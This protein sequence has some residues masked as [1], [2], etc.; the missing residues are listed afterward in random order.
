M[1]YRLLKHKGYDE[2]LDRLPQ[3]VRHKA[4]WAQVLLGIRGRTPSVKGTRGHNARWRRTPVQGN[5]YYMWWIPRSEG[6]VAGPASAGPETNTILIHS[7]R[8]HDQTDE[9]IDAGSLADYE[10]IALSALDPRYQEQVDLSR[11]VNGDQMVLAA[12]KG[13]PGSGKTV[14]LLYLVKD[15]ALRPDLHK[16]LYV[17]YSSRLK[18]AAREFLLAQDDS[19]SQAVTI[20]TLGEIE[21]DLTGLSS[22]S[23]PFSEL[24]D[25]TRLV[26]GQTSATL[27][28]W[29]KHPQAL[30]TEIRAHLLGKTFPP[31][32]SIADG[33]LAQWI[34]ANGERQAA[35]YAAARDLPLPVATL[36][37]NFAERLSGGRFFQDQRAARRAIELLRKGRLPG[38]LAEADALVVDEVQ[39]LTLVQIALLG[40]LVQARM[41]RRPDALFVLTV[42]G[43]ESQIVQP[44]GF[45]W[46]VT[47][48]LLGEQLD[49]WPE[50]F[51]F[52]YQRRSPRNLGQL[53][54]NSWR[55][56][57]HLPKP[58]RPSARRQA[59]DYA[60]GATGDDGYGRILL[61]PPVLFTSPARPD[62]PWPR[63]LA[64][65]SDKPGRILIDLTET[66]RSLLGGALAGER[67]EVVFLAREIKGLERATVLIHGL[68]ATYERALRLRDSHED[69]NI[70][71]FEARRLFDEMRVALSRSTEK[72][73]LLE[74]M[75]APVLAELKI[76]ELS[77]VGQLSWDALIDTLL[78]DDMTELEVIEGY[79]DETDDLLEREM[80]AQAH[81][82]NR[83]AYDLAV[84][85]GDRALQREAEEQYIRS[86]LL[87]A[88]S[89]LR[90]GE[91]SPAYERNR[92]ATA[93]A[94]D[95][96]DPFL[97][98][99]VQD[100][101]ETISMHIAGHIRAQLAQ[102]DV[103]RQSKSY[104]AVYQTVQ[105]A[106]TWV[107]RIDDRALSAQVDE[108]LIISSWEWA[109]DLVMTRYTPDEAQRI[110][111]LLDEA[112][113]ALARQGD[114]EG[115]PATAVLAER[116]R[117]IP[118][119]T[120]LSE[121]QVKA[122]LSYVERYLDSVKALE[123]AGSAFVF[124]ERWLHEA[125]ENLHARTALYARWALLAQEMSL[126]NAAFDP[127]E[128]LWDLEN[129]LNL[130][131]EQGK[132]N[133]TD[134]A[135]TR[136]QAL[137]AAY[138]GDAQQAAE[139]WEQLGEWAVAA[140]FA[141]EAGDLERA[142]RL[143]HRSHTSVPEEL[144]T[145]V[146]AMRLLQQLQHK[147]S[148]LRP[149]ERRTLLAELAALQAAVT[150]TETPDP[151][152]QDESL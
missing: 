69:G 139:T 145:A 109:A 85:L 46:G 75:D 135:V 148:G 128:Q 70:P 31:G 86:Y 93:L 24:R 65:L 28:P 87:E 121:D 47:K 137:M 32:F 117:Q 7:I 129:R 150:G 12:I 19:I 79:L 143:L 122:L 73:I 105:D 84:Q 127:D 74:D 18:R 120:H 110:A 21:Q 67:D 54:D 30:Y 68:N 107:Q 14:S 140:E 15:L 90:Q 94:A 29:K 49:I 44:S 23:E 52:H 1:Y 16:I 22:A 82:R 62:D 96:G 142:Y 124:V 97:Q 141:R 149:A 59:L 58:H 66:V 11:R 133:A 6:M 78:T 10:E 91:W 40:E 5:H 63:L 114:N 3:S 2:S 71:L 115:A 80:W 95:F 36:V 8:H 72:I 147:F 123:M 81:R 119:N 38:W 99:E 45:D 92:Q 101:F 138:N 136:F 26:E 25:F 20:R 106:H 56:Y 103:G 43:D 41:R 42:A 60:D 131:L 112:A 77:G 113:Q 61:C 146:K 53:I 37:V 39:D 144:A 116:Y 50:E 48:E 134:P 83:R 4:T 17:T 130:L 102:A 13:L 88:E 132:R 111:L 33:R 125:Y 9:P 118:Q 100:Q 27:G 151:P 76:E 64:E 89:L 98:D 35:E 57:R 51:E 104:S 34:Q 108:A 126:R 55:F 152:Q